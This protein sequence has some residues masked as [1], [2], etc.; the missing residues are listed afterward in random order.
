MW[1]PISSRG[2]LRRWGYLRIS[3]RLSASWPYFDWL[4]L[5]C[6]SWN[7]LM[8]TWWRGWMFLIM[9]TNRLFFWE[10]CSWTRSWT[11]TWR[12][13]PCRITASRLAPDTMIG[14]CWTTSTLCTREGWWS[15]PTTISAPALFRS[16]TVAWHP[17]TLGCA[18]WGPWLLSCI[19]GLVCTEMWT[20]LWRIALAFLLSIHEIRP[21]DYFIPSLCR[22]G[23]GSILWWILRRC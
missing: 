16:S 11:R 3:R 10:C 14:R 5:M 9:V 22:R 17:H 2:R 19:G 8:L 15:P 7:L 23:Y 20:P 12:T 4:V 18:R 6:V 21:P 1:F 13:P